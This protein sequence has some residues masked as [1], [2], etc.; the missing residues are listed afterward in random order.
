MQHRKVK[1]VHQIV[2]RKARF[3]GCVHHFSNPQHL[4]RL[5]MTKGGLNDD[6]AIGEDEPENRVSDRRRRLVYP[7]RPVVSKSRKPLCKK[8]PA[9]Q[10]PTGI[11]P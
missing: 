3:S 6:G 7:P 10:E 11:D 5:G 9:T 4:G 2:G 8:T 1:A